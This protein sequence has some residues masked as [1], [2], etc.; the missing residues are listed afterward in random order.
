MDGLKELNEC[1]ARSGT[2]ND[3]IYV[4]TLRGS[5]NAYLLHLHSNFY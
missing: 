5:H 1:L 4:R 3:V 2:V